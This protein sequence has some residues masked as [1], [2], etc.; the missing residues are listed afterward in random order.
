M[1]KIEIELNDELE[2][3]LKRVAD[4]V[5]LTPAET[6][7]LLLAQQLASERSI[8]WVALINKAREVFSRLI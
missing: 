1:A 7:K 5:A 4:K 8:D 6:A 3:R 2:A